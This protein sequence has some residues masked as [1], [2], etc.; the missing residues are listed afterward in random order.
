MRSLPERAALDSTFR[1]DSG[2]AIVATLD[3]NPTGLAELLGAERLTA[4]VDIG[5]NPTDGYPP[6]YHMLQ[7]RLCTVIGFEPQPA[8]FAALMARKGSRPI[9]LMP[10]ATAQP[11]CSTSARRRA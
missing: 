2:R 5:A 6:Y 1:S 3:N 4:I 11:A 10:S 7:S 8:E 9:C